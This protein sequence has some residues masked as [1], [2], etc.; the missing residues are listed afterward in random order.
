MSANCPIRRFALSRRGFTLVELL[1]VITIIGILIS[2]LLPAVQAARE[3]ARRGQ[4]LNNVKQL[5]LALQNYHTNFGSY[6]PS[7]VWKV[8]GKF[9]LS[10]LAQGNTSNMYE[11][12]VVMILPQLDNINL[13]NQFDFTQSLTSNS[14]NSS[15]ANQNNQTSRGTQL[16]FMQCPSDPFSRNTFDGTTSTTASSLGAGWARG[17]YAANA[18]LGLMSTSNSTSQPGGAGQYWPQRWLRGVMGANSAMRIDDIKDGASNTILVAEIR[19]GMMP[20]DPRGVWAMGGGPS[21]L[22]GCG[23]ALGTDNGPNSATGTGDGIL[24]CTDA[25]NALGSAKNLISQ[26]MGCSTA[27]A[28]W[29]QTARSLHPGGVNVCLADGSARF[30]SDQIQLGSPGTVNASN[31]TNLGV[32]DKLMLSNDGMPIDASQF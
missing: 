15:N 26:G 10:Q 17:N 8:N 19:A 27:Q 20:S 9:D 21:A 1:V 13:K 6:P 22:W 14:P 12:W 16:T 29:Q 30:I 4:C 18:S 31:P 32:W 24:S 2:L 23:Y 25:Q 5:G 3:S 28:N 7:S 11:N